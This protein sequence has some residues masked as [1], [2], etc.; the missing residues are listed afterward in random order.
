[1]NAT[2]KLLP[3]IDPANLNTKMLNFN[4]HAYEYLVMNDIVNIGCIMTNKEAFYYS[5]S[6][7]LNM[8]RDNPQYYSLLT[9]FVS[10]EHPGIVEFIEQIGYNNLMFNAMCK[11]PYC[12][13]FIEENKHNYYIN[14]F[15][16]A[17]NKNAVHLLRNILYKNGKYEH[18]IMFEPMG[19]SY[20]SKN[21]SPLAIKMLEENYEKIDWDQLSANPSAIHLLEKNPHKINIWY[22]V[23]NPAAIHL[24]EKNLHKLGTESVRSGLSANP[25]A[26]HLLEQ[27]PHL[28]VWHTLSENPAIFDYDYKHLS[29]IRM[30]ILREELIQK[31]MH[32]SRI[33]YWLDNG[34]TIDDL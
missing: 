32:P 17:Q 26:I 25:N 18:D 29:E 31:T 22:L 12:I 11:N 16:L 2:R 20:L 33:Q 19:W 24:I 10:V 6:Y 5:K 8:S 9:L 15:C 13:K 1:M 21:E 34:L 7:L 4:P 28:I 27:N 3:W 14:V 30:N 23:Y